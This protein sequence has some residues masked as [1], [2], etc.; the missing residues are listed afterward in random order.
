M[1]GEVMASTDSFSCLRSEIC[2]ASSFLSSGSLFEP[3]ATLDMQA[4]RHG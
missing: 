2:H 4:A 3:G 1:H